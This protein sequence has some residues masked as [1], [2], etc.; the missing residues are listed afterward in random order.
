M[1]KD[2]G[3][4]YHNMQEK[5]KPYLDYAR[6][7]VAYLVIYGHLL[8]MDNH[9]PRYY[10]YAFHMPFFFMV[11][12]MLHK[13]NGTIQ[14]KKYLRTI[15]I[16]LL[17]FNLFFFFIVNPFY[18][19]YVYL[20]EL[21]NGNYWI[22]LISG[23]PRLWDGIIGE[24]NL[25]SGVTWFLVALLWN[26]LMM[27]VIYCH[28]KIGWTIFVILFFVTIGFHVKLF[29]I[30][31]GMMAFP[32][33]YVGC[34]YK[35]LIEKMI[36]RKNAYLYAL[37]C[38]LLLIGMVELNGKVSVYD[39]SFGSK[40]LPT[41]LCVTLFYVTAI[42]GSV[43][44]LFLSTYFKGNLKITYIATSLITILGIQA[45]FNDPYRDLLHETNYFIISILSCII[46]LLCVGIHWLI[47]RYIPF[48]LGKTKDR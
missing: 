14:W 41:Y 23:F 5:R 25:P 21:V 44:M 18:F 39:V 10:I 38:F 17:F 29:L 2:N 11:S 19:R 46:L 9:I 27:D 13:L 1:E 4:K 24:G 6:V 37:I 26:K 31:N 33:Y 42:V 20:D 32:F 8:P 28:K 7:F 35:D 36:F 48:A 40:G 45:V 34:K 15:G 47:M 3:I 43:M 16:P 30:R 12:G 22:V